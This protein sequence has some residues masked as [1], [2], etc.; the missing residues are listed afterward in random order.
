MLSALA[1]SVALYQASSI[2][3][4]LALALFA[5][6]IVWPIQKRLQSFMLTI[7]ATLAIT[8]IVTAAVRF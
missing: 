7:W 2:L 5:I 4:A 3:V 6:A 8:L 1:V